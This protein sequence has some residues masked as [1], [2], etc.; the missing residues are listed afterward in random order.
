MKKLIILVLGLVLLPFSSGAQNSSSINLKNLFGDLRARH[1]GPALMSGRIND[2]EIHPTNNQII[3]A[4]TAGGGVWKTQDSGSTWEP[5]SDG[6]FGGSIGAIAVSE[7]DENII[8]V[9]EGEQT[10]RGNVSSGHGMWKS[11]DAGETWK[12]IGLPKSLFNCFQLAPASSLL[13]NPFRVGFSA[14][15]TVYKI[16]A[17]DGATAIANLPNC[18]SGKPL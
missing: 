7:S 13:Y 18:P 16:L 9:G 15:I 1:I 11:T 3:Y 2:M 10:L 8:Y 6:Y 4:G 17:S 14:S 5:I 12:Y